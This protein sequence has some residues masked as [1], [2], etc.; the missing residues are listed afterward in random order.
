MEYPPARRLDLVETIHGHAVA[1]PYRW[2]EDPHDDETRTW[3]EA[4]DALCRAH[5]DACPGRDYLKK[6]ITELLGAGMVS[7]PAWRKG[8]AFYLRREPGQEHAVLYVREPDGTERVLVDPMAVDAG[9]T[10]TL[11]AWQPS[12]EGALLAFQLS[13]GGTEESLLRVMD[14]TTGEVVDGPVDRTRYS[15]VAW[16]PGGDAYYYVRRLPAADVPAGEEQLHRRVY[17][18]RLGTAH[19]D[20]T[21]IHGAGLDK[22]NYYGVSVSMDGRWLVVSASAGTA[23]RDDVWLADLH[24]DATLQPVQ[25]GV[26]AQLGLHVGRDG[27]LYVVTDRDAPRGRVCVTSPEQ[28]GYEHWRDLIPER[29]DAVLDGWA[30]T[31]DAI[32]VAHTTHA[33][34]TLAVHDRETGAHRYDVALPGLGA[35]GSPGSDPDGGHDVWFGWTDFVTPPRVHQLDATTGTLTTWATPPGNVDVPPVRAEQVFYESADG[36]RVPMFVLSPPGDV[37]PRPTILNGYGGFNISQTPGYSASVAAWVEAGGT[38]A[39]ACLRG[40]SEEGEEWH[41]AGMRERK[42]NVFDDFHAAAEW[43]R[44]NGYASRLG[45]SGGSNGGLLVGAAATQRPDLYDAVVCSAPLLDMVRYERFG[46]G[47]TWNDEY[48]T[49]D[50]ATEFG[51]LIGY[52]PYHHVREGTPYPATLFTVFDSDTRVD[53]LH[54]R[55]MC[56]AMQHATTGGAPILHRREKDVGHG[57]R[58]VSRSVELAADTAAFLAAHLGLELS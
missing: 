45:I 47:T 48:G 41:R 40:G 44:S 3:G 46:L 5:L 49:A 37:T 10:T 50:E 12:K 35:L 16:L 30:L 2:L 33:V 23:P 43:L 54:A 55:K 18:H 26:D 15:P 42:Q 28:P 6:R 20:D 32:V 19:D 25:V 31:D 9:G 17:L 58:S 7:S 52:S 53:P 1:D 22:T 4:Q 36:T 14:V 13:T 39:I 27:R 34:G 56:A 57:A 29:D 51:W 38:Y 8:R 11:D 24:G 21:E